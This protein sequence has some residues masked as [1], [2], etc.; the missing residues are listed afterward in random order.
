MS[1]RKNTVYVSRLPHLVMHTAVVASSLA[2]FFHRLHR[3]VDGPAQ[4]REKASLMAA[5]FALGNERYT[6]GGYAHI[7]ADEAAREH[8]I[9]IHTINLLQ[10]RVQ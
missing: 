6:G 8:T 10:P 5:T 7:S 1:A 4:R 2:H 9:N 3:L